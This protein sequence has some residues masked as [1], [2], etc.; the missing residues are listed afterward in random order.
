MD[1]RL[2]MIGLV[3]FSVLSTNFY[4]D[5]FPT[6][7]ERAAYL[8]SPERMELRLRYFETLC[9]RSLTRQSDSSFRLIVLTSEELPARYLDRLLALTE[10]YGNV[11]CHAAAAYPHYQQMK[12][13]YGRVQLRRATHRVLFRLDD[14]DAVDTDFVKRTKALARGMIPVQGGGRTPFAIAHNRGLYLEKTAAGPEIYDTCE[15]APLSTGLSLVAPVSHKGNPYSCNHRKI[16]QHY[17]TVSDISVPAFLRSIHGDNKSKPAQMGL[18][19]K[20]TRAEAEAALEQHFG[21][22]MAELAGLLP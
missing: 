20:G 22:T 21:Y 4:T 9:L 10:P 8:F 15:W 19:R 11:L 5:R 1:I 13:A 18:T 3:R 6:L 14:D 7:E 17:N 16:A 2:R 12:D